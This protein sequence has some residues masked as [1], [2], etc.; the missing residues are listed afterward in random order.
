MADSL[1]EL[2]LLAD[3]AGLDVVGETTQRR[4]TPNPKTYIGSGKV[5]ETFRLARAVQAD[6]VL[7]DDELSPRHQRELEKIPT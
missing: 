1:G 4:D 6:V 7:F 3:T 2:A 5:Q